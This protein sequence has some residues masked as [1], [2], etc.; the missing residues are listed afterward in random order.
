M[1]QAQL[2]S[3]FTDYTVAI[4]VHHPLGVAAG[5]LRSLRD[6]GMDAEIASVESGTSV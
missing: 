3:G 4:E 6:R 1:G 5:H 2:Y